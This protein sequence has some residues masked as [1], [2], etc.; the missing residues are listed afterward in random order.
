MG[1]RERVLRELTRGERVESERRR[2]EEEV[3]SMF[4]LVNTTTAPQ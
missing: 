2:R 1:E 3:V 4:E